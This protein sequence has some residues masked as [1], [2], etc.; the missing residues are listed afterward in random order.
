MVYWVKPSL[1]NIQITVANYYYYY[2]YSAKQHVS[3]LLG[4][5]RAY[6]TVVLVKVHSVAF[7]IWD[8]MVYNITIN[9]SRIADTV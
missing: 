9:L 1:H 5:H 7:Y 6:K 2:G 4:H 3:A 8:P